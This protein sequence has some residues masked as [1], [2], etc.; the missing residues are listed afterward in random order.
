MC[1]DDDATFL[2]GLLEGIADVEMQAYL[3]LREMGATPVKQVH[4]SL[5]TQ[6][7]WCMWWNVGRSDGGVTLAPL[8]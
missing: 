1:A 8:A 3:L 5:T 7:G 6:T 2:Q 4:G